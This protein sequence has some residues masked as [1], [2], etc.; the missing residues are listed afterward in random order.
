MQ[1]MSQEE[2]IGMISL[3]IV[4][5]TAVICLCLICFAYTQMKSNAAKNFTSNEELRS[6]WNG[7][8]FNSADV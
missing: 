8:M 1:N 2:K 6:K 7:S 5:Y 4:I 3:Y